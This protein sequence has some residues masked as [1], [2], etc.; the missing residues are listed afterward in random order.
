M[1]NSFFKEMEEVHIQTQTEPDLLLGA[2]GGVNVFSDYDVNFN[3][4]VNETDVTNLLNFETTETQTA[5]STQCNQSWSCNFMESTTDC[6]IQTG[7]I[8]NEEHPSSITNSNVSNSRNMNENVHN[9]SST[10]YLETI[11]N[12]TQTHQFYDFLFKMFE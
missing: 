8:P 5:N 7:I 10:S 11:D 9:L 12:E 4:N 2:G 1:Y 3:V 6:E